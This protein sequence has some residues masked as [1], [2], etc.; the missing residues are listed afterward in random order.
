MSGTYTTP[1]G[2]TVRVIYH[3]KSYWLTGIDPKIAPVLAPKAWLRTMVRCWTRQT[4]NR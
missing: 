4:V 1:D 2:A 3:G